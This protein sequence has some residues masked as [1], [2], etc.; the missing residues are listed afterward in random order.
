MNISAFDIDK[1]YTH[2]T[3]NDPIFS[4]LGHLTC[5]ELNDVLKSI[6]LFLTANISSIGLKKK[7]FNLLIE[8]TQN[9][10][11]YL[12]SPGI[13]DNTVVFILV[14]KSNNIYKIITGN[15]LLSKETA[16]IR[17]RIEMLNALNN[18]ELKA[19]YRGIL[20]IGVVTNKGGAGLGLI[21]IARKSGEKLS[22]N[23][24]EIDEKLSF[25]T[26][27]VSFLND[28]LKA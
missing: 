20:D 26:L 7:L 8:L 24:E 9:L 25:F 28:A 5:A 19:L 16:G 3:Q 15:F 21:D 27:E 2:Y 6:E 11:N 13:E 18:D 14:T 1:R 12:E 23:F 17:S 10:C 22:Y 4:Y